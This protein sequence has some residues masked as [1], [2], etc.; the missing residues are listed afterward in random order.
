[1][2]DNFNAIISVRIVRGGNHY[3]RGE[4]PGLGHVRDSGSA[5]QSRKARPHTFSDQAAG[6]VLRQPRAT[7]SRVHS[8]GH[9]GVQMIVS[10]PARQRHAHGKRRRRIEWRHSRHTPDSVRPKQLSHFFKSYRLFKAAIGR[11]L[12]C[13]YRSSLLTVRRTVTTG[14]DSN[15]TRAL[16]TNALTFTSVV[17]VI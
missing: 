7:F 11:F 13:L 6:D 12:N 16:A 10:N 8:D 17:C 3:P 5:D 2:I 14:G 15:C 1:M 9:F 4:G